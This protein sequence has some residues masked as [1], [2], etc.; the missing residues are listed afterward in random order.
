[1]N[2]EAKFRRIIWHVLNNIK[3]NLIIAGTGISA[4]YDI[5]LIPSKDNYP[6]SQDEFAVFKLLVEWKAIQLNRRELTSGIQV[7]LHIEVLQP[8]FNEICR[9]FQPPE[10]SSKQ[11]NTVISQIIQSGLSLSYNKHKNLN[12]EKALYSKYYLQREIGFFEKTLK[13]CLEIDEVNPESFTLLSAHIKILRKLLDSDTP[14]KKKRKIKRQKQIIVNKQQPLPIT[15]EIV[16]TGLTESLK[17]LETK[18]PEYSGPKFPY[19]IPAGTH[20]NNVIIK[21][22]DEE[23][24]E[25]YVKKLRYSTNY[26]EMG[27]MGKGKIPTPSEQW[28]FLKV[29]AKCFGELSFKDPEARDKYKK[30]K[31]VLTET[32]QNYFSIDYDPFYPYHSSPEKSGNSYKIKLMLL[33][34]P[35]SIK[36]PVINDEN[37]T[38]PLGIHDFLSEEAPQ[39]PDY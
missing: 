38:D 1:M 23:C 30:Q 33:P 8:K 27:M 11:D 35:Q 13:H 5:H 9:K 21:F 14:V 2:Q 25:I 15:G 18:S 19:K 36:P 37:D 7:I 3:S 32:L 4:Q 31:Q 10:L 26:K 17:A 28:L 16:I 29:L 24:V 20:W 22:L 6:S 39:V 12:Q 34:L